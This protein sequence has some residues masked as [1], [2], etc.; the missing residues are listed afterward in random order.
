MTRG[1]SPTPIAARADS[2]P[3]LRSRLFLHA[4]QLYAREV[5]GSNVETD[6][7]VRLS[8]VSARVITL[9][10]DFGTRDAFVGAM[11]G[12]I[13]ARCPGVQLVDLTHELEP[14]D[15]EGGALLLWSAAAYFPPETVHLAVVDPDV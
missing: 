14:G 5:R 1:R 9:L 7:G 12:V 2:S 15:V 3:R 6:P 8:S 13:L 10:T 4:A 11:K